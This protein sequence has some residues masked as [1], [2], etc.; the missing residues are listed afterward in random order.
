MHLRSKVST[1]ELCRVVTM[2]TLDQDFSDAD[3]PNVL[4]LRDLV[5]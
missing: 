1:P 2:L 4:M 3:C 5:S